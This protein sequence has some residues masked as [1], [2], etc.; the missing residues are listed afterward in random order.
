MVPLWRLDAEGRMQRNRNNGVVEDMCG[1]EC[2]LQQ[3]TIPSLLGG[4]KP[5]AVGGI[6]LKALNS[7][8]ACP[9]DCRA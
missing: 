6:R 9:L 2:P 8:C 1:V 7:A 4:V 5:N 3:A